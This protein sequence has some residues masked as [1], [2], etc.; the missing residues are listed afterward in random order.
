MDEQPTQTSKPRARHTRLL[1]VD[2]NPAVVEA[3]AIRLVNQ[4]Y[5]C[6]TALDGHQAMQFMA[7]P[8]VD[9]L[10]TDLDMP[11]LDGYALVDLAT[12]FKPC[13][14]VVITGQADAAMRCY[15]KYPGVP[16]MMKPF[17]AQHI[18][19]ALQQTQPFGP[20]TRSDAA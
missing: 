13:K 2:D 5:E 7:D 8:G 9:A 15:E 1:I 11:Y 12:M 14:C 19:T 17:K 18:V 4:G 20:R 3:L 6:I 10:I 16:V